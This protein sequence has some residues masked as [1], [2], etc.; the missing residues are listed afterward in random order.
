MAKNSLE[1]RFTESAAFFLFAQTFSFGLP[2]ESL[3]SLD[4]I[5]ESWVENPVLMVLLNSSILTLI[6]LLLFSTCSE[7]RPNA[8]NTSFDIFSASI[9]INT[10][11]IRLIIFC[12][13]LSFAPAMSF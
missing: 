13:G 1:I 5:M 3:R 6:S 12:L 7:I 10:K 9:A 11:Y 8:V 2:K 4:L